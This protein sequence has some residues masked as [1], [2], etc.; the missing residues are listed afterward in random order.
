[1]PANRGLRALSMW[2]RFMSAAADNLWI[3]SVQA[4]PGS[5]M[6]LHLGLLFDDSTACDARNCSGVP[7]GLFQKMKR[8]NC[9]LIVGTRVVNGQGTYKEGPEKPV[10]PARGVREGPERSRSDACTKAG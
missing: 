2:M 9:G 4:T 1:M 10:F 5:A 7:S 3:N 6:T 8:G